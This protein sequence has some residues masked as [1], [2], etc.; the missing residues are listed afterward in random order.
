MRLL[1]SDSR[2]SFLYALTFLRKVRSNRASTMNNEKKNG[3]S[4]EIICFSLDFS[5]FPCG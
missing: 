1:R 2:Q 5:R 3:H 4:N